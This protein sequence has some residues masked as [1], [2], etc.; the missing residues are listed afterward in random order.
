MCDTELVW[1]GPGGTGEGSL[2]SDR[3]SSKGLLMKI[4][5][6]YLFICTH[7]KCIRDDR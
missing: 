7:E 2:R 3:D 6:L 4:P 1:Q 5:L